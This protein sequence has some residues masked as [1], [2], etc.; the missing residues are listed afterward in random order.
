M[1]YDCCCRRLQMISQNDLQLQHGFQGRVTAAAGGECKS[2]DP[3]LVHAT[4]PSLP[5]RTK[6]PSSCKS[7]CTGAIMLRQV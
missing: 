5:F 7:R 2:G 3:Y 4:A 6:S 1:T